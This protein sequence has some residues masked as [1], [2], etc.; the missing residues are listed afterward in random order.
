MCVQFKGTFFQQG[1]GGSTGYTNTI[2]SA[3]NENLAILYL[4]LLPH[5]TYRLWKVWPP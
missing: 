2:L 5:W 1:V 4:E 3:L